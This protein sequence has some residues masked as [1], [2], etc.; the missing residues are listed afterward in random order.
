MPPLNEVAITRRTQLRDRTTAF[1]AAFLDLASNPPQKLLNDHFTPSSPKITEHGPS[2]ATSKLPF[3]GK[4][5]SGRGG[6]EE[7]FSLLSKV[8]EFKPSKDTFPGPEGVVVDPDAVGPEDDEG[9]PR[10]VVSLVARGVFRAVET[11]REWEEVF[12]YRLSGFDEDGKIGHWEIWA[13]PL[14]A[15][16]AVQGKG[17]GDEAY[18]GM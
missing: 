17:E 4:T 8:L 13:D 18:M 5:F 2:W 6:C 14:S 1:T 16:M 15:W 10:G 7:Y 3:L 9:R 12:S 11:G